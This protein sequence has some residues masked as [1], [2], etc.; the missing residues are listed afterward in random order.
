MSKKPSKSRMLR[1]MADDITRKMAADGAIA[2]DEQESLATA[3]VRQ[4]VTYDGVATLF[5]NG[6]QVNLLLGNTPLGR[7]QIVPV[8]GLPGWLNQLTR[9]WMISVDDLPDVFAQL[10]CGQSAEV[11]NTEGTPLRLWVN[12]KEG[13]RGVEPLVTKPMPKGHRRDYH[14]MARVELEQQLGPGLDGEEVDALVGSIASQWQ[15]YRGHASLFVGRE[16]LHFTLTEYADG[17]SS[18]DAERISS[19]IAP[20]LQSLGFPPEAIP[21]V[22]AKLNLAQEIEFKNTDG[23]RSLMWYDPVARHVHVV[24]GNDKPA[25]QQRQ[26]GTSPILCPQCG[27]VLHLWREGEKLQA[28]PSCGRQVSRG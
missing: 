23:A 5:L 16:Q 19:A 13:G 9:D 12:P 1:E 6:Q 10:N 27:A 22:I 28:C 14:K 18:V 24:G 3:L 26:S 25:G 21:D 4:W 15:K 2:D 17:T 8:P 7:P 11:T 20:K